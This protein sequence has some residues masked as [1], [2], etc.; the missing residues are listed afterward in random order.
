M[1]GI[2]QG[3]LRAAAP[4]AYQSEE[5]A[6]EGRRVPSAWD[7][8]SQSPATTA[9]KGQGGWQQRNTAHQVR[10]VRKRHRSSPGPAYHHHSPPGLVC[11]HRGAPSAAGAQLGRRDAALDRFDAD[12]G[13]HQPRSG[14]PGERLRDRRSVD[15]RVC[16]VWSLLDNIVRAAGSTKRFG[17]VNGDYGTGRRT[18]KTSFSRLRERIRVTRTASIERPSR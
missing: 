1:A 16:S 6:G 13:D 12:H 10:Q 2:P 7:T 18:P 4:S 11:R 15:V 8:S 3:F 5:T 17:L 9:E 14:P